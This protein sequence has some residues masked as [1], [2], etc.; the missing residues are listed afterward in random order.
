MREITTEEAKA[1]QLEM[2]DAIH[3]YC[4]ANGITYF[5]FG[6]TAIG[7]VRHGGFIPWDDDIDIAMPRESYDRFRKSFKHPHYRVI[8]WDSC[9]DYPFGF[10]KVSDDR[11]QVTGHY[12]AYAD[13]IYKKN[14]IGLFIDIFPID[15]VSESAFRRKWTLKILT[16][17]IF[18]G[19][20]RNAPLFVTKS[21]GGILSRLFCKLSP[22]PFPV[23]KWIEKTIMYR[24]PERTSLVCGLEGIDL[25]K[26]IFPRE[27]FEEAMD[28][29]FE[30]RTYKIMKLYDPYLKIAFGDYMT[31]P[32]VEKRVAHHEFTAYWKD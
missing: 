12:S 32:P 15:G 13:S 27:C 30:G 6:G 29:A 23:R 20:Q 25:S 22:M 2:M 31:P 11:Q 18:V 4:V 7:A 26:D 5:L 10:M 9:P 17:T 16:W 24:H 8:D 19:R 21:V 28:I 14:R 1:L 3:D